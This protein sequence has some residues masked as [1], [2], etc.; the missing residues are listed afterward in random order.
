MDLRP[1]DLWPPDGQPQ[2]G[3]E[4]LIAALEAVLA[5]STRRTRS[6]NHLYIHAVEA[7]PRP[8]RAD[9]AADALRDRL[10]G[11]RPPGPHA[12]AHRRAA[13]PLA[14]GDHG[15]REGDRRRRA[16][17]GALARAGLLPPLHGPQPPHADLRGDDDGPERPRACDASARWSQ[18]IPLDFFQRQRLGR[19]LH[20]DAARGADAVRPLGRRSWPSP[21]SPITCRSRARCSTTRAASPSPRP[22]DMPDAEQELAAF[23]EARPKVAEGGDFRQ[24]Q[25]RRHP[26]RGRARAE[27]R[28]RVPRRHAATRASRSCARPSRARTSC[29][30]TSRPTGSSRC[31]TRSARRC[32]RPAASPRP[33]PCSARTSRSCPSNG[34]GLYGLQRALALQK[35]RAEAAQ[36]QKRFDAVWSKADVKI[37]SPCLCLPGV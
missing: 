32:S 8:E 6:R 5:R 7:S 20:G 33:R 17:H 11:A 14:G 16:L 37:Q 15:Q 27:G 18:D 13:R 35:K 36:V 19:R 3:T 29:A 1:W 34:W 4:E 26:R 25:R 9:A 30:T 22:A 21:R 24:Q 2:P 23:L 10:P 28:D 12:V 31:A